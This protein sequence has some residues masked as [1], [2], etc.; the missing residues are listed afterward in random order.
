M[1]MTNWSRVMPAL[2]TRMSILPNW[3]I[4]ALTADLICSSSPTSSGNAAALP[5]AAVIS[6]TSSLSLSR[7]R[8]ATATAAPAEASLRAHA[9][10]M[11]C[12]APVTNAT[13]PARD[14]NFSRLSDKSLIR[15][16]AVRTQNYTRRWFLVGGAQRPDENFQPAGKEQRAWACGQLYAG[17]C[18]HGVGFEFRCSVLQRPLLMMNLA[19]QDPL[20]VCGVEAVTLGEPVVQ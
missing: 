4:A 15:C 13:C 5:P 2:L 9:R 10:P 3:A 18:G 11:P 12:D 6:F 1:R 19:A 16:L 7:L 20:V 17:S 14:M 8:A